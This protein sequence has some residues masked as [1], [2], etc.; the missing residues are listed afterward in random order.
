[1]PCAGDERVAEE[2]SVAVGVVE[3]PIR[4]QLD[5]SAGRDEAFELPPGLRRVALAVS[6]LGRVDLHETDARAA[7]KVERVAVPDARDRR[8]LRRHRS[9]VRLAA[10]S[11]DECERDERGR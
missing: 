3:M 2:P 11:E 1:M 6:E 9:D 4:A 8:N 5:T 7:A 10:A